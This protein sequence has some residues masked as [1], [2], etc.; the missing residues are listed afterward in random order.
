MTEFDFTLTV[1]DLNVF[2]DD[3]IDSLFRA[4]C[5]DATL[6]LSDGQ[7]VAVFHRH[8]A[9][10]ASAVSTAITQIETTVPGSRVVSVE[11]SREARSSA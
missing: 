8:A 10:F 9:D 6:A 2:D 5:G 7:P 3:V 4:G 1:E 11:R